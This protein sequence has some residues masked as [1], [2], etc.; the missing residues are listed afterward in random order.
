[1]KC[2][3]PNQRYSLSPVISNLL[4]RWFIMNFVSIA[5]GKYGNRYTEKK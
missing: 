1:M 2:V 5:N 4:D 3:L